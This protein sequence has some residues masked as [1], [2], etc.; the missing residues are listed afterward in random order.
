MLDDVVEQTYRIGEVA[1]QTALSRDT[2]RYYER[3]GLLEHPTRTNG[4]FRV[5]GKETLE[6]LRFIKRAQAVGFNLEEIR[7]LVTFDGH[8][9]EQCSRVRNLVATK[10]V[11]LDERLS[12]L[13]AFRRSLVGSLRECD[14]ALL[15]QRDAEC[16]VVEMGAPGRR[17]P[18]RGT[19]PY[20]KRRR[21]NDVS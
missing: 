6:R 5:Y 10:L 13:R 7:Q 1:A 18:R 2:L 11:E 8:G 21:A 9:L 17:P 19:E 14:A 15:G 16:P 4:G 3:R 20:R 12:E